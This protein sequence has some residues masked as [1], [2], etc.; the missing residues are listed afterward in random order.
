MRLLLS[1][2]LVF[3]CVSAF[4]VKPRAGRILPKLDMVGSG[5]PGW[6]NE[7]F[8]DSLG[9]GRDPQEANQ[10]YQQFKDTREAFEARQQERLN[11]PAG[12]EFMEQEQQQMPS[13]PQQEEQQEDFATGRE[14]SKFREM[15]DKAEGIGGDPNARPEG[16]DW[17]RGPSGLQQKLAVPLDWDG[18]SDFEMEWSPAPEEYAE[19]QQQEFSEQQAYGN[20]YGN[21]GEYMAQEG[22][23]Y[24][25]EEY[26]EQ[27]QPEQ[28]YDDYNEQ[29]E[30]YG[31]EDYGNEQWQQ[32]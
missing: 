11:S 17:M 5:G 30:G 4:T 2:L 28:R 25:N 22:E 31:N 26:M 6:D 18:E 16:L 27:G 29:Q 1:S 9:G 21:E 8:L 13:S 23:A 12:Q 7:G 32:Y 10:D 14:P 3:G 19:Q 20:E 24:G 15:M